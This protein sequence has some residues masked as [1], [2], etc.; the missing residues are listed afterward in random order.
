RDA[1]NIAELEQAWRRHEGISFPARC[2]GVSVGGMKLR[3][4]HSECGGLILTYLQTNG[5]LGSRQ[6]I[7]IRE[8]RSLVESA[9]ALIELEEDRGYFQEHVK[10]LDG[11]I[12][13]LAE[14]ENES[15]S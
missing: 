12:A 5:T 3:L 8:L 7:R 14:E 6:R 2:Y 13:R 10:M 9:L 15:G 4:L 1:M 11:I